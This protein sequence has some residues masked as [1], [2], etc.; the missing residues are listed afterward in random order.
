MPKHFEKNEARKLS[1]FC[2]GFFLGGGGGV[3][4]PKTGLQ[5]ILVYRYIEPRC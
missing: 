3:F 5:E 1:Y 2:R 4:L